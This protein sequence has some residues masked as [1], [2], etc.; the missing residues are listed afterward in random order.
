MNDVLL[1]DLD[2][3]A[4]QLGGVSTR[5]VRRMLDEG[6]IES[7]KVGRRLLV[8]VAS[9]RAY[10]DEVNSASDNR[11]GAGPDVREDSTCHTSARIPPFGGCPS[12]IQAARELDDL[13]EPPTARKPKRSK[14]NGSSS[15]TGRNNGTKSRARRLTS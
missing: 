15:P 1:W 4:R 13:L 3:T 8:R 7:R 10:V 5:T 6:L 12:P 2:E 9:V 14:Q 11:P